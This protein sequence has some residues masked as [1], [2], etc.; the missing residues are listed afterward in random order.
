MVSFSYGVAISADGSGYT[1]DAGADLDGD[2]FVQ[3]WG[4]AKPDGGGALAPGKVGCNVAGLVAE[5]LGP[6]S[7]GHGTSIF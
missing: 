1:A 6:C 7:P 2:G 4:V 5:E 3:F